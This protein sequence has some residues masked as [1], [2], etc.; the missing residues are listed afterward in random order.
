MWTA[1][2]TFTLLLGCGLVF[3]SAITN[4]EMAI[5]YFAAGVL[6]FVAAVLG[7]IVISVINLIGL[8]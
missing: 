2:C 3:K 1:I 5:V 6:L 7:L 8:S 4:T